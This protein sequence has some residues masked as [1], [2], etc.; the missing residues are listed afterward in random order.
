MDKE[1]IEKSVVD[2][3]AGHLDLAVSEVTMSSMLYADLGA[4]SL[5]V[6]EIILALEEEFDIDL[7]DEDLEGAEEGKDISV[8]TLVNIVQKVQERKKEG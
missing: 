5:A 3:V 6:V 4:D 8:Q 1:K 2:I 7:P